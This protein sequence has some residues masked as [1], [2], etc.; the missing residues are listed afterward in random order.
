MIE[1]L[2]EKYISKLEK[3]DIINFALENNIKL[4]DNEVAVIYNT[5][6]LHWKELVFGNHEI[7]LK[8]IKDQMDSNTYKKIEELIILY[9]NKYQN[10]L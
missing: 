7:V 8:K 5:I 1:K 10:Y 6:Q 9:K 4:S 2:I 3:K